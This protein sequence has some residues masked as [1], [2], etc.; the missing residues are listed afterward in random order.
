MGKLQKFGHGQ[1]YLKAGF[2]GFNK[3]GKTWT[4][5][6]LAIGTRKFFGMKGPIAIFDTEGGSEYIAPMIK[7]ATGEDLV[8]VRSRS[9]QD[10]IDT[11]RE[12]EKDGISV[13]IA[14][15]MTHPWR[16]VCASYLSKVNEGRAKKNQ[17]PRYKLEFQDWGIIKD[18]WAPW[19]DLYI[20]SKLHII[21][22]GRAGYEYD[23]DINE[24]TE[25]RELVKTGIKMKTESEFGFEPSLLVEMERVQHL[26]D[27]TKVI[28]RA[29]VIGDR[30]GVIDGKHCDNPTFEFFKPHLEMLHAGSYA[31][32]DTTI[33]SADN[34]PGVDGSGDAEWQSEKRERTIL[35]E[36]IQGVIVNKWPGQTAIE[37]QAKADLL[38]TIF[39]TRSW[40][41]VENMN[42]TVLRDGLKAIK[43]MLESEVPAEPQDANAV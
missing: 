28:H 32:V 30:F 16:E 2:V 17:K 18:M 20:N 40:T 9:L 19:T 11:A 14:D 41:K 43:D 15:S 5:A 24:E 21:I 23:Y 1:G 22:C 38:N 36:E 3:S 27:G 33:K 29:T 26:N 7:K 4:A 31:P 35:C 12:C 10:L 25:R 42:S 34:M 37:K 39:N 13:L 6:L 8:G